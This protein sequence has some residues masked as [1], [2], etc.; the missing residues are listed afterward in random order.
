MYKKSTPAPTYYILFLWSIDDGVASTVGE[1]W[2]GIA[3][4]DRNEAKTTL[5]SNLY[6]NGMPF[7]SVEMVWSWHLKHQDLK[8]WKWY[9]R[10]GNNPIVE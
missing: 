4:W 2:N 7:D 5:D 1:I 8:R 9:Q 10:G 3:L 6:R